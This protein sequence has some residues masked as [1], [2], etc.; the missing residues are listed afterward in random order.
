MLESRND[1]ARHCGAGGRTSP[2]SPGVYL[3]RPSLRGNRGPCGFLG[4]NQ[5]LARKRHSLESLGKAVKVLGLAIGLALSAGLAAVTSK[6]PN[7]VW[8]AWIMLIP[9]LLAIRNLSPIYAA[10]AGL[11]WGVCLFAIISTTNGAAFEL[12]AL[13][14]PATVPAGYAWLGSRLTRRAGFCPLLLAL[15][16]IGVEIALRPI[17]L[18]DGLLAGTQ[19]HALV[20]RT[21][22]HLFG[23]VAVAFVVVYVNASILSMLMA[24]TIVPGGSRLAPRSTGSRPKHSLPNPFDVVI[25]FL[26][27]AQARAPPT[28]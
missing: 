12:W 3:P 9:L 15:G 8:P 24:M 27:P 17:G 20:G 18:Q 13:V 25:R 23:Y 11:F 4:K 26:H 22:G 10:G 19:G 14:L 7:D 6:A 21:L 2:A 5:V 16:W 1:L 28:G